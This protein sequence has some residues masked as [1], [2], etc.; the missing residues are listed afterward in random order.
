[1][2]RRGRKPTG[3]KLVQRLAGSQHAKTRLKIILETLAGKLTIPDACEELGIQETM[4]HRLRAEV[5]QTALDRLEP[6]PRGRPPRVVSPEDQ[7][8]VDLQAENRQ[9]QIELRAAEIRRE[10]AEHL[11]RLAKPTADHARMVPALKKTTHSNTP[12]RATRRRR[13]KRRR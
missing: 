12:T 9:L 7:R 6:R 13:K 1:M 8:V 2:T 3:S 11:P 5:L 4:F 10:L